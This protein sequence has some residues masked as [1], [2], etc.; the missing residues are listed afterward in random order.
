V[1]RKDKAIGIVATGSF[2]PSKILTNRDLEKILDTTDEWI[3]T[4]TG[5]KE[6][7]IAADDEA[8]S[9]LAVKAAQAALQDGGV[10][11]LDVNLIV[12][13]TSSPDMIQPPTACLVQGRI[14]ACNAAAFDIGAVCS[15]FVY[16][17]AIAADIMKENG[18][19]N[20]A[21]V[22]GAET[23][24]KILDWTDRKTCVFFGDGAG[25]VVLSRI[26]KGYGII[27][28][29]L[30]ADGRG[31]DIIKFPAGGTRFPASRETVDRKMHTFQMDGKK[32]WDFAVNAFPD[33]VLRALKVCNLQLED[34]DFIISH[35]AN[36]LLIKTCMDRLGLPLEKTYINVNKYGNTSGASVAIALDE[37]VKLK[38][39]KKDDI[40]VLVGFGGGLTWG[41]VVV[42]WGQ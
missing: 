23:Y 19:Y 7:R 2:V 30:M 36:A 24:S 42:R 14:G 34:V 11:P 28:S 33:A 20:N 10:E 27:S 22:I 1:V 41:A 26:D 32:V 17:L 35:Q 25:A 6:R 8:T 4:K 18:A 12:L 31:W 16:A 9:D 40:V 29:Y 15:G 5:I 13:A 38:K 37:A 21:L 39:I 3:R